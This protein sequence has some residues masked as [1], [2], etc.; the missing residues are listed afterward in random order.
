MALAEALRAFVLT[1]A[2]SV[3]DGRITQIELIRIVK[4]A[5]QLLVAALEF[6]VPD[7]RPIMAECAKTLAD[8][9]T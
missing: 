1:F 7:S 3:Q 9:Q 2:E 6:F 5:A 4:R 8:I